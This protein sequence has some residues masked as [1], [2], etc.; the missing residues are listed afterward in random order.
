MKIAIVGNGNHSKRIQKI[1][2]KK[3]IKFYIYRPK[4]KD[5]FDKFELEKLK[6]FKVIF[7]LSPNN[8]HLKYIK[9][10]YKN[11]YIFCEKPPV[12]SLNEL[13]IL[14]K[15]KSDKLFF[16]YNHR[17][18]TI[19]EIIKKSVK[20]YKLGKL[21]Y[22]NIISSHGLAQKAIYKENWRSKKIKSPKG[23]FETVSIHWIDMINYIF[24]IKKI[25]QVDLFNHSKNGTAYDTSSIRLLTKNNAI[26]NIFSTY[27]SSYYNEKIFLF[28]NGYIFQSKNS[29][30]VHGPTATFDRNGNFKSPNLIFQLK[31][32]ES[33]D[34][35]ESITKSINYFLFHA[36][37]NKKFEK[38]LYECSLKSNLIAIKN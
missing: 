13:K 24:G 5:Y 16:N 31:I 25:S 17:F 20:K 38:K 18:S 2:K 6:K 34:Y 15:L 8:S 27:N 23:V 19:S 10:N 21:V 32:K 33:S 9:N 14:K 12:N 3:N 29:I 35:I 11:S 37:T 28:E 1:L 7:I 22:S 26:I 4:N 30:K 36:K